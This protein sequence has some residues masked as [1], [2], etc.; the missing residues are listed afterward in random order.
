MF[1]KILIPL[2]GSKEAEKAIDYALPLAKQLDSK[3][4]V[5]RFVDMP[6]VIGG[7][8]VPRETIDQE[9]SLTR[10]YLEHMKAKLEAEGL[11][12]EISSPHLEPAAG[13]LQLAESEGIDLIVMTS[14]GRTG[15][16]RFFIGSVA[17]R[18]C[19]HACCP[20]LIVGRTS[21][22]AKSPE[23]QLTTTAV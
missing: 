17:E 21:M 22:K 1:H 10:H 11:P 20:V 12:V 9:L 15:L 6:F 7:Y 19:R 23:L 16:T 2:D 18:V 5:A 4:L 13:I 8:P 3:V 14:H